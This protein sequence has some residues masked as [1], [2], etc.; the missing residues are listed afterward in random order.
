MSTKESVVVP[1][2]KA[3]VADAAADTKTHTPSAKTGPHEDLKNLE[4]N[5]KIVDLARASGCNAEWCHGMAG[6]AWH[7]MLVIHSAQ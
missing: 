3:E 6:Y 4:S 7:C 5:R 2:S 1:M